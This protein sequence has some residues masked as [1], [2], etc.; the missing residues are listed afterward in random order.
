MEVVGKQPPIPQSSAWATPLTFTTDHDQHQLQRVHPVMHNNPQYS[1]S[2]ASNNLSSSAPASTNQPLPAVDNAV[3]HNNASHSSQSLV[4]SLHSSTQI[5]ST[6]NRSIHFQSQS[7]LPSH[8][9]VRSESAPLNL[10]EDQNL[11]VD[12]NNMSLTSHL[13]SDVFAIPRPMNFAAA[14]ANGVASPAAPSSSIHSMP[15]PSQR[16]P[17]QPISASHKPPPARSL[18]SVELAGIVNSSRTAGVTAIPAHISSTPSSNQPTQNNLSLSG[19]SRPSASTNGKKSAIPAW[20]KSVFDMIQDDFPRTPAPMFSSQ[21]PRSSATQESLSQAGKEG[22]KEVRIAPSERRTRLASTASLDLD[23]DRL[24]TAADPASD[25]AA[26]RTTDDGIL[27]SEPPQRNHRRS[28]S[29]N[30]PGDIGGLTGDVGGLAQEISRSSSRSNLASSP[31]DGAYFSGKR[32]NSVSGKLIAS[33]SGSPEQSPLSPTDSGA[34]SVITPSPP[35]PSPAVPMPHVGSNIAPSPQVPQ[36]AHMVSHALPMCTSDVLRGANSEDLSVPGLSEYDYLY[37][38]SDAIMG[39]SNANSQVPSFPSH[40]YSNTQTGMPGAS[41]FGSSHVQ[42]LANTSQYANV[43]PG[44]GIFPSPFSNNTGVG[45]IGSGVPPVYSDSVRDGLAAADNLKNMN[46]QMAAFIGVQQQLYAAQMAQM[47]AITGSAGFNNQGGFPGLHTGVSH[48]NSGSQGSHI[49]SPWEPRE[50]NLTSHRSMARSKNHFDQYRGGHVHIG[51]QKKVTGFDIAHKGRHG[52]GRRG[53]RGHE[54]IGLMGGQKSNERVNMSNGVLAGGIQDPCHV[55]SPLLEE[56][57]ATSLSIGRSISSVGDLGMTS[58]YGPAA[59]GQ[60]HNGREWQLSEIKDSV[61]E[62]AT[63][64]HGSRFIQQKLESASMEDKDS[65]LK[66][67]LTDAQRLMTDVF[68]NYVVQK[69]LDHGGANAVKLIARELEGRMLVLSLHMY[70]CRVVQKALEVLEPASRS[71][72]VRELDGHVLKCIRDQNGN[73]VI[74]KCV[75]LVEPNS[76]QFIVDSVQGQSVVLAGHSYG[77]R[78]VQRILE[79]GAPGQK[80][81]IMLEIMSCIADLIKDQYGNYVI[82]H[83]VEHGTIEERSIIM[84]LVRG[85]VCQLSQHKFASNVVER[86]L[87]FGSMEERRVLIELLINGEGAPNTSPLNH[88]VRDQFGNYVV[89][90][91]LDVALLPQR[92]RVVTILRAQ[93]PAIKKY[94]YGKHIIARLEEHQGSSTGTNYHGHAAHVHNS[95]GHTANHGGLRSDRHSGPPMMSIGSTHGISQAPSNYLYYE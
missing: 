32:S 25:L 38:R 2:T 43:F 67:A 35:K 73:H 24:G 47:A 48:M 88:L 72:L 36:Q 64:Q 58:S 12:L 3:T 23:L 69:L 84:N 80:A 37:D 78:V 45:S 83:V 18:S 89:Q 16:K 59:V 8:S 20:H 31:S 65:I 5:P 44:M 95:G 91:V 61:V 4:S 93:V 62:F 9:L 63:D 76:V 29:I 1:E 66:H 27:S 85:E 50:P 11:H 33:G 56:F 15:N 7:H 86:C 10:F 82:Q 26:N 53:N 28:V 68:G 46:I 57:R 40:G 6:H 75:E 81:P 14:A 87:Q 39:S 79:H 74:Q 13:D 51:N 21:V 92:E 70:G 52:R 60:V 49:R 17:P 22:R 30:W 90:R 19:S 55:R 71:A 34:R 77:C 41:A 42:P 94:S 54:D